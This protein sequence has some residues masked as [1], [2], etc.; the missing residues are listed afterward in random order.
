MLLKLVNRPNE[1]GK[2][3]L[4][5]K[6]V[7]IS[8][9]TWVNMVAENKEK[10]FLNSA[11]SLIFNNLFNK[12][13]HSLVNTFDNIHNFQAFQSIR[14]DRGTTPQ[15]INNIFNNI[16]MIHSRTFISTIIVRWI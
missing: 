5:R 4:V 14:R 10:I 3:N 8:P 7:A 12:S 11:E 13:S 1:A 6:G 2:K 9:I 16:V 15:Y